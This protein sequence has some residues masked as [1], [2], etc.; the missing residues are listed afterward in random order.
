MIS[1]YT[2]QVAPDY[3][4]QQYAGLADRASAGI[5]QAT[6]ALGAGLREMGQKVTQQS[7]LLAASARG[8]ISM[9]TALT[10]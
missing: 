2:R 3:R 5:G 7:D 8:G 10:T 4:G 6:A 9:N 1:G